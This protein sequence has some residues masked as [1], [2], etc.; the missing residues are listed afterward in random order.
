MVVIILESQSKDHGA[1]PVDMFTLPSQ[2]MLGDL[3]KL[4]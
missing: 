1:T 4:N 3:G 2:L